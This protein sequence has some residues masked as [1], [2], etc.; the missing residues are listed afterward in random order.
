MIVIVINTPLFGCILKSVNFPHL[1]HEI[2]V[3][4]VTF[5]QLS[6]EEQHAPISGIAIHGKFPAPDRILVGEVVRQDQQ[7]RNKSEQRKNERKEIFPQTQDP[8]RPVLNGRKGVT[9]AVPFQNTAGFRV[10]D[11]SG[12]DDLVFDLQ[13]SGNI[14]AV[15]H[16]GVLHDTVFIHQ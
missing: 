11:P 7:I 6:L 4:G 2:F 15:E 13:F 9:E 16:Y 14:G 10:N 1:E 8:C 12:R 5:D 3:G